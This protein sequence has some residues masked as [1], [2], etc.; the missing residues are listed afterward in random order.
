MTK[1]HMGSEQAKRPTVS[2]RNISL[3]PEQREFLEMAAGVFNVSQAEI[4]RRALDEYR[5]NHQEEMLD[6]L[7][8]A[9]NNMEKLKSV[10]SRDILGD[11]AESKIVTKRLEALNQKK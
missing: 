3:Y 6:S 10:I 4:I 7:S 5:I 1:Q 11:P 9:I 2:N 8:E